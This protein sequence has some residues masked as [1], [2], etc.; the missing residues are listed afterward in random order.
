MSRPIGRFV[1]F[2]IDVEPDGRMDVRGDRWQGAGVTLRELTGLRA[3]IEEVSQARVRFNWFLRFDAQIERTWGRFDWLRVY[4]PDLLP[5]LERHR[6]FTGIHTHFLRWHDRRGRWFSD[7]ADEAWC[8]DC[9]HGA[10][11]GYRAA[12]GA[13]PA[14]SRFGDRW[15]SNALVA[16]LRAEGVR[17]DLTLEPGRPD[18]P[19]PSD[20]LATAA[21]P[22]YRRAPRVP[23]RPSATDFLVPARHSAAESS[24]PS[25]WLVPLTTTEPAD[26]GLVRRFP[27]L[28]RRSRP[29]NLVLNPQ[30]L[31]THLAREIDRQCAEPLVMVLRSGDL[32][33]PRFLKNY[34]YVTSRLARHPG[35]AGCRFTGVDEALEHFI[36][37]QPRVN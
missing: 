23:Y 29:F 32:G 16:Q 19:V 13:G 35:L 12:F 9:L 5:W 18:H 31:W 2:A 25:L 33:N 34:R 27:Y 11:E 24:S 3:G 7:F 22:D 21:T 14:A 10:I 4:W 17:Y 37:A 1:V 8:A 30:T 36:Q 6:D 20:P 26:W 28:L 15:L